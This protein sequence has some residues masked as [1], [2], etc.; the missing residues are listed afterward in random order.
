MAII[1][2][3]YK[4]ADTRYWDERIHV[5]PNACLVSTF[6][7]DDGYYGWLDYAAWSGMNV[8]KFRWRYMQCNLFA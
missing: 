4:P 7:A 2:R 8:Q 1:A 3:T 5:K 6:G